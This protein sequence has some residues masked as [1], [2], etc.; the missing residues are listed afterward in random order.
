MNL[1]LSPA[2]VLPGTGDRI[3]R[4]EHARPL[5]RALPDAEIDGMALAR[6]GDLSA[7]LVDRLRR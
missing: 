5:M 3:S 2:D 6:D 7:I 1:Q 4:T